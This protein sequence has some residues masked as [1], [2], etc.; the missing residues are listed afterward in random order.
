MEIPAGYSQVNILWTGGGIP[1]G[2]QTTFGLDNQGSSFTPAQI[3][4]S[5]VVAYNTGDL[6]QFQSSTIGGATVLVKNGPVSTGPSAEAG[7]FGPGTGSS[8]AVP[9]NSAVLIQKVTALGGR[10][11]RGRMYW[12][13]WPEGNVD[14]AGVLGEPTRTNFEAEIQAFFDLLALGDL[15]PVLL[16]AEGSPISTPTPITSFQVSPTMATQRRRLRR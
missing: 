2:A 12:P 15:S 13:G 6:V 16:H 11:G 14:S 8:M 3:A 1:T 9:P 7:S 10:A 5:V 4:N